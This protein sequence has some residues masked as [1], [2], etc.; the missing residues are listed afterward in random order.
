VDPIRTLTAALEAEPDEQAARCALIDALQ[1]ERGYSLQGAKSVAGKVVNAARNARDVARVVA[2]LDD[3]SPRRQTVR[4]LILDC[5]RGVNRDTTPIDV[6]PGTLE[7]IVTGTP[8]R[9]E[10]PDGTPCIN[11]AA[12]FRAGVQVIYTPESRRITVGA[13]WVLRYEG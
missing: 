10:F 6:V 7:P 9:C 8:S 1:D 4:N 3:D 11:P 13:K 2:M 12:A 5:C